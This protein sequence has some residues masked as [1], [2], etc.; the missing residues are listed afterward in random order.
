MI[1]ILAGIAIIFFLPGYML[2]AALFP[3]RGELDPE[4]DVIYRIALGMGLSIVVAIIVGFALNS[5]STEDNGYVSAG[6][7]WVSLV[8]V[9]LVFFVAGWF[10]GAF[11]W[12]GIIHPS[13]YRDP[14][15]RRVGGIVMPPR[16]NERLVS[17][18]VLEREFWQKELGRCAERA[19]HVSETRRAYYSKR[20]DA[21]RTAI[22][23]IN[24][25]LDQTALEDA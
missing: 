23:A 22:D 14:P 9:T 25:E 10:R 4:Y 8:S 2:V 3:R 20:V 13:L 17:K 21:A 12:M 24:D 16:S 6:P 15:P 18:L 1:Q 7:L 19:E 5:I 11:P